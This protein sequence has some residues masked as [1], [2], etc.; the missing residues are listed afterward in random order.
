MNFSIAYFRKY[1]NERGKIMTEQVNI[2]D[3]ANQLATEVTE[4]KEFKELKEALDKAKANEASNKIYTE[5]QETQLTIQQQQAGGQEID[6]EKIKRIQELSE[7]MHNDDL[8][9]EVLKHE[10]EMNML[11]NDVNRVVVSPLTKLYL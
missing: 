7:E 4:T 9:K 10:Q 5:F 1:K 6:Q 2:Y 3:T 8:L 11:L